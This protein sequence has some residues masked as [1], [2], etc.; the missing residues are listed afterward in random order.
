MARMTDS[1]RLFCLEASILFLSV[2]I[3][4]TIYY[5]A[6]HSETHH[7]LFVLGFYPISVIFRCTIWSMSKEIDKL[8]WERKGL[9]F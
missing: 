6:S 3:D 2:K 5:Y 9:N 7:I 4:A 1:G 8:V